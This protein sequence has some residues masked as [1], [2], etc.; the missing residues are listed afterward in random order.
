MGN[1]RANLL[2]S[3][4][5]DEDLSS[6]EPYLQLVS[7]PKDQLIYE[8]GSAVNYFYFPTSAVV[9]FSVRLSDGY[10]TDV[11]MADRSGIFP[12]AVLIEG[13]SLVSVQVR[14]SGLAYRMPVDI[15][16]REF[17]KGQALAKLVLMAI[18]NLLGQ[19]SLSSACLRHHTTLQVLAKLILITSE[20]RGELEIEMTHGQIAQII[21][22]RREAITLA[23]Q[24]LEGVGALT[25]QRGRIRLT[26]RTRLED[27]TCGC[28]R[29]RKYF[30]VFQP[31]LV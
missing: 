7:M 12:L 9:S 30:S 3:Q 13:D 31:L 16:R 2:L 21:G 18:R 11:G 4:L 23:L 26:D 17:S 6:L 22:V 24:R 27:I 28:Y 1:P 20:H 29:A 15:L 25:C 10:Q 8:Q 19:L 5:P 14:V